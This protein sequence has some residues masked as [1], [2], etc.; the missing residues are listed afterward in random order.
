MRTFWVCSAWFGSED[1][2]GWRPQMARS[3]AR[4]GRDW[5]APLA[6]LNK[7]AVT[8]A[9]VL[10]GTPCHSSTIIFELCEISKIRVG[11]NMGRRERIQ[12]HKTEKSFHLRWGWGRTRRQNHCDGP[13]KRR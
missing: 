11:C 7:E 8:T 4:N 13:S 3:F 2:A 10:N 6:H 9:V 12:Q 5:R 1:D